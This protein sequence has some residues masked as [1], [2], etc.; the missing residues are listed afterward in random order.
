[1]DLELISL[2]TGDNR[3]LCLILDNDQS[4]YA[5]RGSRIE[6]VM[7]MRY[8][9]PDMKIH[10]LNTNYRSTQT[11]VDAA[12]SLIN[13]NTE[14]IKKDL[15]SNNEKGN[16]IIFFSEKDQSAEADRV[17]KL[18]KLCSQKYGYKYKDIAILYRMN[19]L[20][21]AVEE[22]LLKHKIP[23]KIVGGV[24]FYARKEIKD[25][26]S[27]FRLILNPNDFVAF[28]RCIS[29]PK[30][31]IGEKSILKIREYALNNKETLIESMIK[32]CKTGK[33]KVSA[34]AFYKLMKEIEEMVETTRPEELLEFLLKETKYIEYVRESEKAGV[35]EDRI[36]NIK[37]LLEVASNFETM[38]DLSNNIT[39]DSE[40]ETNDE[41]SDNCVQLLSMHSSK[42]LEWNVVITVG[43]IEGIVPSYRAT[44]NFEIEEERRLYYVAATRAKKLLF[45]TA[46]KYSLKQGSYVRSLESRFIGEMDK[47]Y[48]YR[49]A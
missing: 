9:Y 13:K 43:I 31:G 24:N 49:Y 28:S 6:E 40:V 15:K 3:N 39:L 38:E 46:P 7:K 47:Q 12:K 22:A 25:L 2:L 1:M 35:A 26:I 23:Y 8:R 17:V 30:R 36:E 32:V 5:F 44:T 27:Y 4:I 14:L 37:E 34:E 33:G 48:I 45:I 19:F 20:S 41:E 21:R 16:P 18:I 10:M 42:G 29:A 11:I